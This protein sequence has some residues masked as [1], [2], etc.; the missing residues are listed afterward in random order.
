MSFACAW[1]ILGIANAAFSNPSAISSK[2]NEKMPTT[3]FPMPF[4]VSMNAVNRLPMNANVDLNANWMPFQ[5][6]RKVA[7]LL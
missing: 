1:I 4:K 3:I 6:A 2:S 5:I 7:L